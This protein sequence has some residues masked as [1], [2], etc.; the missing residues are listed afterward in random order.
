[1]CQTLN[2][3]VSLRVN[4]FLRHTPKKFFFLL[5]KARFRM[6]IV[7]VGRVFARDDVKIETTLYAKLFFHSFLCLFVDGNIFEYRAEFSNSLHPFIT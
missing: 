7:C 3:I 6:Y 2:I 5:Q 4:S 1:M